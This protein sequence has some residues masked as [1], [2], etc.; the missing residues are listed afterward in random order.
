MRPASFLLAVLFVAPLEAGQNPA[1]SG[2]Q[3]PLKPGD[4]CVIE[5][6]VVNANTGEPVRKMWVTMVSTG[7]RGQQ[8][9]AQTDAMGRFAISEIQPGSYFLNAQGNGYP[10]QFY[11]QPRP[12][13]R[14]TP[15]TLSS[16][17]HRKD[18]VFRLRP[19]GV[20]TGTVYDEDGDPE[21]GASVQGVRLAVGGRSRVMGP[22]GSSMTNDRGEY[23]IYA[24]E[25]GEYYVAASEQGWHGIPQTDDV[26]VPTFYPHSPDPGQAGSVHVRA[27]DEI[28]GIDLNLIRVRGVR[29]TGRILRPAPAKTWQGISVQLMPRDPRFAGLPFRNYGG[30]VEEDTGTFEFRGVPPGSYLLHSGWYYSGRSYFGALPLDVGNVDIGGVTLTLSPGINLYGRVKTDP[31]VNLDFA[32]LGLS[33]QPAANLHMG[34]GF[35][36]PKPDGT[37]VIENVYDGSYRLHVSGFP[38]EFYVK[39]ARLGGS[40]VLAPEIT[41]SH[42]ESP[43]ALEV[44]LSLNGGRIDGTVLHDMKPAVGV[45]VVLVPDAPFRDRDDMYSEKTTDLLGRFSMLGLPP[46]NFKLFAWGAV[47]EVDFR[48]PE[49]MKPYEGRGT[50]VHIVEKQQQTVQLE[51]ILA[52][53]A[54][55]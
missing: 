37:F 15:L 3:T 10:F 51:L 40:E 49:F 20:I 50:R 38:E 31:G 9:S 45:L 8:A 23:R 47:A 43:G 32:Q 39:S 17:S 29:L 26:Y 48:D 6:V 7:G 11:G 19:G 54:A 2:K 41:I 12:G 44:E 28:S 42:T 25:P 22:G 24:L 13:S 36:K 5:G 34:G 33:L 21:V 18:I 27:G 53:E 52:E 55:Q 35:G 46:G 1:L 30:V 14:G 4:L 16:G